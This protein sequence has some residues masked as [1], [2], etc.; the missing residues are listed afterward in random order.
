VSEVV[1]DEEKTWVAVKFKFSIETIAAKIYKNIKQ[2]VSLDHQ[3]LTIT[4]MIMIIITITI[5][6]TTM[7]I[8]T[9]TMTIIT[10]TM[11]II[12]TTMTIITTT[13]T[14]ITTTITIVLK[15][16]FSYTSGCQRQINMGASCGE[17][18]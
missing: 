17:L 16:S 11:T 9:T 8:I 6:T 3:L 14:I 12:T 10:T 18:P 13:M 1:A 7:T 4:I 15:P 5:I 2:L